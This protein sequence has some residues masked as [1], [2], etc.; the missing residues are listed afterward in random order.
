[1]LRPVIQNNVLGGLNN[2][3]VPILQAVNHRL[4]K[5]DGK[6]LNNGMFLKVLQQIQ[7]N[8]Y[9]FVAKAM[10]YALH[11]DRMHENVFSVDATDLGSWLKVEI[12]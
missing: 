5:L 10:S 4:A 6:L 7:T 9:I 11:C 12:L 3:L 8:R 1:M 2:H